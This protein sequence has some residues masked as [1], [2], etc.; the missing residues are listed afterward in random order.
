MLKVCLENVEV[1]QLLFQTALDMA[2]ADISE[3]ARWFM[4][5]L[6]HCRKKDGGGIATRTSFRRLVAQTVG[7]S[8]RESGTIQIGLFNEGICVGHAV[9]VMTD[10]DPDATILSIDGIGAHRVVAF[11][12]VGMLPTSC[13]WENAAGVKHQGHPTLVDDKGGPLMPLLFSLAI[14]ALV[15][16]QAHLALERC[17]ICWLNTCGGSLGSCCMQR[18][19]GVACHGLSVGRVAPKRKQMLVALPLSQVGVLD[20]TCRL[21]R[22]G[23]HCGRVG[24]SRGTCRLLG[25]IARCSHQFGPTTSR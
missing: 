6:Q 13:K 19:G 25:R 5:T 1:M 9:G 23:I 3:S 2:R 4:L 14:H 8:G 18:R 11:R 7:P 22:V 21:G 20:G 10:A 15:A 17:S 24:N 12:Q 16:V